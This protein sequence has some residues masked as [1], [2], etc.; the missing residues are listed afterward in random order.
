MVTVCAA[1]YEPAAG[2]NVGAAGV[3]FEDETLHPAMTKRPAKKAPRAQGRIAAGFDCVCATRSPNSPIV[4]TVCSSLCHREMALEVIS[5]SAIRKEAGYR[6]T[7][8]GNATPVRN[9]L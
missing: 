8:R 1:L 4:I 7:Y 3:E 9:S 5:S 2:V 6:T